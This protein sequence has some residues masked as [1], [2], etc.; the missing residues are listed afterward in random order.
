MPKYKVRDA[1]GT[2]IGQYQ[3][4]QQPSKPKHWDGEWNVEET[5]ELNDEAVEW[6]DIY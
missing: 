1:N 5:D 2:V 6:W 4:K 3:R